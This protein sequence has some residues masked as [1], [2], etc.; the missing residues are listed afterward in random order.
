MK[1]GA[2]QCAAGA[3]YG[4]KDKLMALVM[5]EVGGLHA[6]DSR[7]WPCKQPHSG[8]HAQR[9]KTLGLCSLHVARRCAAG[10]G[11][12]VALLHFIAQAPV[13]QNLS[14]LMGATGYRTSLVSVRTAAP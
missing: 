5:P 2:A 7:H 13:A 6:L 10:G 14:V 12:S 1:P 3:A 4:I 8:V 11:V 9:I